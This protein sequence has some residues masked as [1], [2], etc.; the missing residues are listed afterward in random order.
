MVPDAPGIGE[1]LTWPQF[2]SRYGAEAWAK[3]AGMSYQAKAKSVA[4]QNVYL[5]HQDDATDPP[6][7]AEA[8]AGDEATDHSP[9]DLEVSAPV[10]TKHDISRQSNR[11]YES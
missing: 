7:D 2:L 8:T 10:T 11:P 4:S 5:M 6:V 1:L 9:P 3:W